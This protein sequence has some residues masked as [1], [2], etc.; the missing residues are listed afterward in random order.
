M[1]GQVIIVGGGYVG[2]AL[3]RELDNAA[4]V[5]LIEPR[6]HFVH[7][8]AMIRGVV[9]PD[10]VE[11]A[12]M[13][14]DGLLKRGTVLQARVE[15][16]SGTGVTL[17]DGSHLAADVIVVAT[18]SGYAAPFKPAGD[19]IE[20]FRAAQSETHSSLRRAGSVAII[21]AGAVGIELAGEIKAA[22][23]ACEVTLVSDTPALLPT[24]PSRLGAELRKRLDLLGV[25][26]RLGHSAVSL[27]STSAP[28]TGPIT[29]DTGEEIAADLVFPVIGARPRTELL[30]PLPGA[31]TGPDGRVIADRWMRPSD[32]PNVLAAG[33]AVDLGDAMTI[34]GTMRQVPWLAR[35]VRTLLRGQDLGRSFA[36][37]AW[38]NPPIL[39]PLG[40]R[41]GASY[42][43]VVGVR[44]NG[45]TR[46]IKGKTLFLPKHRGH[47]GLS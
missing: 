43:P 17:T 18:G 13:P 4:D 3:A 31:K 36:Y 42:L 7:A 21:G 12:L 26:L 40:P 20:A 16:V 29:L 37:G 5:T 41:L 11:R 9:Q 33:D 28:F 22:M 44:G 25:S 19:D 1:S 46:L 34:V 2:Y 10:I 30:T 38:P 6:S 24:Y 15:S 32:L 27:A 47:F 35:A 45:T 23:P 14:Y 8:A 39:L